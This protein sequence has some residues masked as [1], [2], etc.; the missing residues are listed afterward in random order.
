MSTESVCSIGAE[1][2]SEEAEYDDENEEE[3]DR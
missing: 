2:Y 1:P 3:Y